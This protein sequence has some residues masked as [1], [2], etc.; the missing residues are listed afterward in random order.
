ME[1][2]NEIQKLS[3]DP[4]FKKAKNISNYK[5]GHPIYE[6]SQVYNTK[7]ICLVQKACQFQ[8]TNISANALIY[9]EIGLK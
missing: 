7:T 2:K 9:T 6:Y 4:F 8:M 3:K 1:I 5:T